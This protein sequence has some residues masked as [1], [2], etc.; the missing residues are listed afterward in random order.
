MQSE[1]NERA[2]QVVA[3]DP[4]DVGAPRGPASSARVREALAELRRGRPVLVVD[5]EDREDEGDLIIAA[6]AMTTATMAFVLR[7]SSG[8]VCVAMEAARLA[9]LHLPQMVPDAEDPMG[10]AFTVSVDARH[11]VTTGISAADR[12]RT[13]RA[14][15]SPGTSP[16]DLTR[17]G[18]VFPLRAHPGGVL[19][20]RGHTESAVDLCRLAGLQ[21]VGVLAEVMNDDGTMARRPEL[22]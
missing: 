19:A 6:E 10:T 14:L 9:E 2:V 11:D 18:H 20:R 4:T 12:T 16:R 22:A 3:A 5:D 1:L 13:V 8:V 21:P 15:A 17:P 7:H